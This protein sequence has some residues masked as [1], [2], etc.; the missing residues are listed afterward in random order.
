MRT[1]DLRWVA[2]VSLL[3]PGFLGANG[4][5]LN[6]RISKG[7][8]R[9]VWNERLWLGYAHLIRPTYPGFPVEVGGVA[10]DHAA[11]F[12]RKPQYAVVG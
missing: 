12:E 2:Q 5:S 3:R 4:A 10:Q 6:T 1:S 7:T 9:R 8:N 11:F